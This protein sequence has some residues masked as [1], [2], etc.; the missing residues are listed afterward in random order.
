[1]TKERFDELMNKGSMEEIKVAVEELVKEQ[2]GLFTEEKVAEAYKLNSTIEDLVNRYTNLAR[3]SCFNALLATEDPMKAAVLQLVYQSIRV[4]ETEDKETGVITRDVIDVDKD[5]DLLALNKKAKDGI[6]ADKLW[7]HKL[8]KL[9][10]LL[11]VS[12]GQSIGDPRWET[13]NLTK[14]SDSFVMSDI[15]KG[16]E[17]GKTPT[18]NTQMLKT[19]TGIVQSMIGEEYKPTSHDVAFLRECYSRKDRKAK[20]VQMPN[21]RT[22]CLLMRDVCNNCITKTGYEGNSKAVKKQG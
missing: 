20:S 17:F 8:Q 22:F 10:Y 15:A 7:Y 18:S 12:V 11:A 4:K 16:L 9:N 6:G 3:T 2:N 19:L 14:I 1:M 13:K 21:H 5:I